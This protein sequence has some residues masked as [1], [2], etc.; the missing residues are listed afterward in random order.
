M[1]WHQKYKNWSGSAEELV[2]TVGL[3]VDE[4]VPDDEL[5]PNVRLLRH[6]QSLG[7][8]SK[9]ERVGKGAV[10]NYRHLL[11][12][13]VVRHLVISGWP[14]KKIVAITGN[15][16][17]QELLKLLP[18]FGSAEDDD[19]NEAQK[20]IQKIDNEISEIRSADLSA[21][22]NSMGHPRRSIPANKT[23]LPRPRDMVELALSNWCRI[24]LEAGALRYIRNREIEDI[25]AAFRDALLDEIAKKK[26]RK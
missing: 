9:P 25:T 6:Y 24:S 21:P 23:N 7:A 16:S 8:V 12:V 15:S 22:E 26:R 4:V 14:L 10:Y 5:E 1:I 17:E 18:D 13:V 11:E 19:L 3:V 20:I 2:E